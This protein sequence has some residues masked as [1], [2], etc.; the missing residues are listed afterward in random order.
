MEKKNS[1]KNSYFHHTNGSVEIN[2][3][4]PEQWVHVSKP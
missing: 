4:M 3:K 2:K 1:S